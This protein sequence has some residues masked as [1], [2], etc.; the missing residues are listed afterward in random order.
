MQRSQFR[1]LLAEARPLVLPVVTDALSVRLVADAGFAAYAIGGFPLVGSRYG[2]PDI[3]LAGFGEISNGVRDLLAAAPGLPAL[4]D[5]DDGYGDVKNVTRTVQSYEAMGAAGIVIEDQTS[6]KRCGHMAG[7]D[8]VPTEHWLAK[9]RAAVAARRDPALFLM[10]R[11]DARAVHGLDE[12]L[13]RAE[14]ALATGVDGLFVEAPKSLAELERVGR[15][16]RGVPLLANMLEDGDT[17]WLSPSELA[18]LGF[19]MIVYPT[20][21]IFHVAAAMRGV[22]A[23]LKAGRKPGGETVSFA[24][25]KR[26]TGFGE[27]AAVE[28]RFGR[29]A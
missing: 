1:R 18:A 22:L 29:R 10:A 4:V 24:E 3:G 25:F 21:L 19:A 9:L 26:L 14:A 15:S 2:I 23:D 28:D 20:T 8:V 11:T 17:P 6:P 12:A 16:F 5:G 13:R 7:K 27:W